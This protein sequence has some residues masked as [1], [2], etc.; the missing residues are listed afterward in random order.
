[1]SAA[2][3]LQNLRIGLRK[4]EWQEQGAREAAWKLAKSVFKIKEK[5]RASFFSPSEN[6][7]LRAS[8]LKPEEREFVVDSGASMHMISKKDLNDAEMDTLTKSCSPT[9][10]VIANG[11]VQTHEEA[12]VYVKELDTFLTMKVLE[13]R[14]QYCR[15]ESVAM[16]TDI[17]MN[18]STVKN[19][20]SFKT[21]FGYPAI[22]RTSFLLWFQACQVRPLDL[23]HQ[24]QGRLQDRRV[25][26][27]HLLQPR[28]LH[29]Q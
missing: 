28:L 2:P 23:T 12:T 13:T 20:I 14:Q 5:E 25:I 24:L 9:I 21:G 3:T 7:C 15:L 1:M 18:G 11:E 27:P 4:T 22:R 6:W 8:T 10:V 17:P 16:K 26:P 19:H 29:L